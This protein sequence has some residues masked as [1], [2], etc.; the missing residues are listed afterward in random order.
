[1]P[2]AAAEINADATSRNLGTS[3]LRGAQWTSF[4]D[5]DTR[6]ASPA[7]IHGGARFIGAIDSAR[8]SVSIGGP[9]SSAT[10]PP[11]LD[12]NQV[13]GIRN[14]MAPSPDGCAAAGPEPGRPSNVELPRVLGLFDAVL[15]VIGGIVG[16]GI[17]FK[18]Q[19]LAAGE[20]NSFG[21]IIGAWVAVGVHTLCGTL[22]LAELAAMLPHAGGPYIYLREAYGKVVGFLWGWTE[23]WII[24]TASLGALAC[25]TVISLNEVLPDG[26][27]LDRGW[28][29]V[30]AIGLILGLALINAV[31]TRW[32][33]RVQNL[34][35]VIKLTFLAAII[36]LPL[37]TGRTD[38]ENL[39]PLWPE[40]YA[41]GF[42]RALGV[43]MIAVLWPYNGWVNITP[44]TEEIQEPQRNLPLALGIGV[45]IV[46]AIYVLAN[47]SYHLVLPMEAIAAS[48][49]G[50]AADTFRAVF[51]ATGA[52]VAALGVMCS[53]LGGTT[54]T[55][56]TGPRIYFAMARD[57]MLPASIAAVHAVFRTPA[58]A[59]TLQ[60]LWAVALVVAAFAWKSAP[61]DRLIDAFDAL[62]D[63]VIFG[64]LL[65][66]A[67]VVAAVIVLRRRRP[68][69]ARP[70]R[71][72]GY[73]ATPLLYLLGSSA[74]MIS[75]LCDKLVQTTAGTSLIAAGMMYYLWVQH[76]AL[77]HNAPGEPRG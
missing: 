61:G 15:L 41:S 29:Q 45:T 48:T 44:V 27:R 57:G 47:V 54:S 22:A 32:G 38:R 74:V 55:L 39:G 35:V 5:R 21:P 66:Y 67:L 30:I 43:A 16:S 50:V 17:F 31:G 58:N 68:D 19:V 11:P 12:N 53:T 20:L 25:A 76:R 59:I 56:L 42:W 69:L 65:F 64:A 26:E 33:A 40:S 9:Q 73:P 24:R 6:G 34:T 37:V 46:V 14:I 36:V 49:G 2:G 13:R 8:R 1:M 71:T 10:R 60:A 7:A 52:R 51:G 70:Y 62:T 75:M 63:F 23:F 4:S 3:A 72:W 18:A 28:Q 77:R